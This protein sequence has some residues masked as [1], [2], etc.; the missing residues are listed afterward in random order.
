M[1]PTKRAILIISYDDLEALRAWLDG[2]KRIHEDAQGLVF[3]ELITN[4]CAVW[5]YLRRIWKL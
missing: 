3:E 4:E 1:I 5:L 2:V